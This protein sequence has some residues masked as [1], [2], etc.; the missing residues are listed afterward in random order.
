MNQI[1]TSPKLN[2]LDYELAPKHGGNG[3]NEFKIVC[4][5]GGALTGINYRAASRV[6]Q[7]E[8]VCTSSMGKTTLGPFGGNGGT[9]GSVHCP[10]GQ[11]ISSFMGRS[12]AG[13]DRL[14]VRCRPEG[15][16]NVEG[17]LQRQ[18]GGDGGSEFDELALSIGMRPVSITIRAAQEVDAIQVTYGN[19]PISGRLCSDCSGKQ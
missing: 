11:Y 13:L 2:S 5:H 6:D 8:F 18:F 12:A 3:G 14:G 19:T 7:M 15:D 9:V 17:A 4:P 1:F 16:M 10:Q